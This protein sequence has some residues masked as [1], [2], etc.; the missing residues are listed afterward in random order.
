MQSVKLKAQWQKTCRLGFFH[1]RSCLSVFLPTA[2]CLSVF[3]FSGCGYHLAGAGNLPQDVHRVSF[4]EFE[5][6]TLEVGAEKEFQWALE[7]EFR[8]HSGI[9]VTEDGEGIVNA[10][11]RRLDLRPLSFDRRDQVLEY[12]VAVIF[13][14]NLTHRDSGQVLWQANNVRVTSDYSAIPQVVVTTSPEFQRGTLNPEDLRGLTDVQFSETQ[15]R[16]AVE[17]LF[18][19]AA[20]EVYFRLGDD[21]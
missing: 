3:L 1:L 7:R 5:N 8:N 12:E 18:A 13:D 9:T 2:Y 11:L 20:R 4:A 16:R 14:I 6:E 17:R 19:A 15:R 21:F 10:V